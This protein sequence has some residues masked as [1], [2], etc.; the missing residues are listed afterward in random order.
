MA[1]ATKRNQERRFHL[2]TSHPLEKAARERFVWFPDVLATAMP[3]ILQ[4]PPCKLNHR[5]HF[6]FGFTSARTHW[7]SLHYLGCMDNVRTLL[8][9]LEGQGC[10]KEESRSQR[11][12]LR[13]LRL[14][15][16]CF[17]HV[18]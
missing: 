2:S 3:K 7:R 6:V 4:M 15:D 11:L 5:G 8:F 13:L 17:L 12:A 18:L 9:Q 10:L 16:D 14:L 1:P